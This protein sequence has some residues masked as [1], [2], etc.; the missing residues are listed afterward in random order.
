MLVI[1]GIE[2]HAVR[3]FF[4]TFD[5]TSPPFVPFPKIDGAVHGF[6]PLLGKPVPGYIEEGICRR[7]I[8]DA[9]EKADTSDRNIVSFILIFFVYKSRYAAD[10]LAV[11]VLQ[12]PP[13]AFPMPEGLVPGRIEDFPY[14]GVDGTDIAWNCAVQFYIYPYEILFKFGGIDR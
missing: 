9:V 1:G 10:E 13:G 5:E 4:K 7:L 8:I 14:L 3:G 11:I 2:V 12:Y 6:H